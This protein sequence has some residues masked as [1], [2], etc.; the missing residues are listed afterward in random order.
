MANEIVS[1]HFVDYL[2]KPWLGPFKTVCGLSATAAL[3]LAIS[4][5][6]VA[7]DYQPFDWVPL[8][9]GSNVLMGYYEY[10]EHNEFHN[11]L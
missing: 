7:V 5:P 4:S 10:A 9:A 6:A 3:T 1:R 11:A 2:L 8:P